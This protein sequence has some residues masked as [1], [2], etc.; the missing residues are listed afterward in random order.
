MNID[1]STSNFQFAFSIRNV[2]NLFP[3]HYL[4]FIFHVPRNNA[5]HNSERGCTPFHL[6]VGLRSIE[7]S[8]TIWT[9]KQV[10]FKNLDSGTVQLLTIYSSLIFVTDFQ[11]K[12]LWGTNTG[13]R[14]T[15]SQKTLC[16]WT[17]KISSCQRNE[18]FLFDTK[19]ILSGF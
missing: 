6:S 8:W 11:I 13:T 12:Y 2:I 15:L 14:L 19:S 9:D 3:C 10:I 18:E 1:I 17:L 7:V 16:S 4:E 5:I